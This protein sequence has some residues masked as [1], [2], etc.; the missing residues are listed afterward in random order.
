MIILGL[1]PHPT[2]HTAVALESRGVPLDSLSVQ[3]D[4]DGLNQLCLVDSF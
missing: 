2:T 4:S 3:N 1:D